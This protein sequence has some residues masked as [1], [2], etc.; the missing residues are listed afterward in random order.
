MISPMYDTSVDE[1][2]LF[3]DMRYL[4]G[5]ADGRA[6]CI[7]RIREFAKHRNKTTCELLKDIAD[8]LEKA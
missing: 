1:Y 7:A 2:Q 6:H 3:S 4:A 5:V 8:M